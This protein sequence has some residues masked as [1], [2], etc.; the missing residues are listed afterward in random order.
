MARKLDPDAKQALSTSGLDTMRQRARLV[1][2]LDA[3]ERLGIAPLRA[4]RLHAFAYLA[5]VLSPVWH[6]PAFDGKILKIEGGP[7]YPDLQREIDRLVVLGIVAV[8]NVSYIPRPNAGAR[9]DG[10]YSLNFDSHELPKILEAV[11]ARGRE[12]ALDA[13]DWEVYSFLIDLAG[14]LATVPDDEIGTAA[15]VDATYADERVDVSNIIDFGSW[16]TDIDLDNLSF[17]TVQRFRQFLPND[18]KLS[19]SEKLYLYAS[20]LGGR[21]HAR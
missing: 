3:A 18:A 1:Q 19:S 14:A 13:R 17:R 5:D 11:G 8:S 9:I 7:H 15:T 12:S 10:L 2:M 6:L 21:V 4:A 20:F 16:S